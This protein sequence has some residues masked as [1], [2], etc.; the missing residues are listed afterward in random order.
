MKVLGP[1]FAFLVAVPLEALAFVVLGFIPNTR[2]PHNTTNY[3]TDGEEAE[4]S[5]VADDQRQESRDPRF[6]ASHLLQNIQR[7]VSTLGMQ[8][9]LWVGLLALVVAKMARPMLE[10]ILQYMSVRF[11]WPLSRVCASQG[12][13]TAICRLLSLLFLTDIQFIDGALAL[14]S[15][16][17]PDFALRCGSATGKHMASEQNEVLLGYKPCD[18]SSVGSVPSCW[19]TLH[20]SRQFCPSIYNW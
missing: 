11:G 10:L 17:R 12:E 16:R 15:S 1:Y 9:G 4:E 13:T 3:N 5:Q 7:G 18:D 14:D 20:G 2:S 6:S 8:K 19:S